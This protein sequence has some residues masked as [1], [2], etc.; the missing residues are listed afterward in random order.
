MEENN[1][2]YMGTPESLELDTI[3]LKP[4]EH[5]FLLFHLKESLQK[6]SCCNL[7]I[8]FPVQSNKNI[9]AQELI[10]IQLVY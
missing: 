5:Y 2:E 8:S 7:H 9:V 3:T 10:P 4:G 6:K 1:Q